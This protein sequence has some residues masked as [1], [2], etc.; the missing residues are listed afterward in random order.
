MKQLFCVVV[1][2]VTMAVPCS[3]CGPDVK[4][5]EKPRFKGVELY[6]WKDKAGDWRFALLDGTNRLKT[7]DKVKAVKDQLKSVAELKKA[8]AG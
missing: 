1:A 6:S 3:A 8:S 2:A 4:R 7:E 5:E